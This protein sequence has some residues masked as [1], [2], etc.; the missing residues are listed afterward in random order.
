VTIDYGG[1]RRADD[2][3]LQHNGGGTVVVRRFFVQEF[4][5]LY[6]SC[7][8]CD[9]QYARHVEIENVIASSPGDAVIGVNANYGDTA[10]IRSLFVYDPSARFTSASATPA[11]TRAP[12]RPSS[13]TGRIPSTASTVCRRT[14]LT[15]PSER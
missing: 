1:A 13:A 5:K 9:S 15:R 8:N 2:K 12:S 10:V 4:G 6:R 14:C 11:T 3:V 7:G